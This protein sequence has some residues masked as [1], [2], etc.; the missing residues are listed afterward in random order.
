MKAMPGKIEE[1]DVNDR[2]SEAGNTKD[3][4]TDEGD[5]QVGHRKTLE[6]QMS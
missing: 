4:A 5:S 3:L 2:N 6:K 1:L